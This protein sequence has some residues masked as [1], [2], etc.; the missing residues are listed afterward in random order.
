M[1]TTRLSMRKITEILR[2]KYEAKLSHQKIALACG[3][4]KGVVAKYV[5]LAQVNNISWPLP[6][7]VDEQRLESLLFPAVNK[8]TRFVE[9]DWFNIHQEL[10]HQ[11]VTLQLLWAEYVENQGDNAYRYSQFCHH[12]RQ[13]R[14][15]QR[16]SMRQVHMAGEK[17]FIDYCGPT[18]EIIERS[19]G[20]VRTAQIF[21][22]VMGASSYTFAEAT[23]TQSLPDWIGSHQRALSFLGGVPQL[24]VPDNLRSAVSKP[25]RYSPEINPTYAE[26]A[27]H[28]QTA[29]LPARPYKPKDKAKAEAGVLLVER[30]ILARLRHTTFFSL[31]QLNR[32]IERLLIELN[33]R[34]FQGQT[35]SR[36]SLF[37]SIDRPTLKPLPSQLYEY[38][39]W[40][41][42]KPGIDYHI[43]VEKKLYSVP[44]SLVGQKLDVRVT[45]TVVE[46]LHKGQRVAV[47]QKSS[48]KRFNT[49]PEHMPKSHRAHMEWTPGRF[50]NWAGHI[51]PCTLEV[52]KY[53]LEN[54]P[55]PE[56]GYRA[57]LGFKNF[58]RQYGKQRLEKA[59]ERALS[60]GSPSYSSVASILKKGLDKTSQEQTE[61]Q[62]H[63]P[64]HDNLRGPGYYH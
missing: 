47:H 4:S 48:H 51:G 58:K 44:N 35:E 15:R 2:L 30:W 11:G 34:P 50:M 54:R 14:G 37:D 42:A 25:D 29:V 46:I 40:L 36:Q 61:I 20:E 24:L 39:R 3:V 62:N 13:W 56:H 16:R 26:M 18:V 52:I 19:T 22:A 45:D 17:L 5:S 59:C 27:Q 41:K 60:I 6:D 53:Q 28:Y 31:A 63:L 12:Y 43:E 32:E 8:P 9:P 7:G 1:P 21:V 64:S 10:K 38:A 57:C 23:W 49:V 33:K 55:H